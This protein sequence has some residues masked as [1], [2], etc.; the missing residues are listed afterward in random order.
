M[1]LR[2]NVDAHFSQDAVFPHEIVFGVQRPDDPAIDI[3]NAAIAAHPAIRAMIAIGDRPGP[4]NRKIANLIQMTA[5]AT[6]EILVITDSDIRPPPD[7]L[8]RVLQALSA[9][10]VGVVTCPYAG[11][12]VAGLWSEVAALGLSYQ[13]LPNLITGVTLGMAK[14][15]MGSTIALRRDTLE[16]IGGF[17]AFAHVLADDYA[18]GAAVRGLGLRSVTVPLV[19]THVCTETTLREVFSHELRW[20]R[21]IRGVDPA[22]HAGS[23]VT[24]PVPIALA[25][26]F[27][28]GLK[29]AALAVLAAAIVARFLLS[30]AIDRGAGRRTR[31]R[32]VL[33]LRDMLSF[34]V[35]V[36]SFLGHAVEWRGEKF[37]VTSDGDLSP[38][39]GR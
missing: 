38:V 34:T 31:L 1:R 10:G 13:F 37:H 12:G 20:A 35:F 16:R 4:P 14:P 5:H 15:C 23:V 30:L 33:P 9:T 28:T 18:I 6:G 25:G 27:L 22:G 3:A 17:E 8:T 19:V 26:A 21:T 29:P 32:W 7:H 2:Q 11:E 24:H 39:Q 36:T